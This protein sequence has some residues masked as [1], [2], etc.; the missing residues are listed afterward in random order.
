VLFDPVRDANPFFHLFEAMWILAGRS[1]VRTLSWFNSRMKDYSD[2]GETFHAP[3]GHRLRKVQG[4]DQL[5][6][7]VRHLRANPYSR[8]AVLQIWDAQLDLNTTTRDLPCNDM[9]MLRICDEP[10]C[11]HP[12]G[13]LLHMTVLCRS[14]DAIWGA[15]GA[16]A[17]QFS[18]LLEYLAGQIGVGVGHYTQM[19]HNLHVYIENP[20][21]QSWIA[22]HPAGVYVGDN[23]YLYIPDSRSVDAAW[24]DG[25]SNPHFDMDLEALFS[26]ADGCDTLKQFSNKVLVE[27]F[28]TEFFTAIV[29]PMIGA[30]GIRYRAA[31]LLDRQACDWHYAGLAWIRR[32]EPKEEA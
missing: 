16:N 5:D 19:S 7:V 32:R 10:G 18:F 20:Y 13:K 1:D 8:Q 17:V 4:F 29:A 12:S 14:N 31:E 28:R 6:T 21:W 9:I 3:Y 27:H 26:I 24:M 2:D 22:A 15:Y 11:F 25:L 30:Y 23:P